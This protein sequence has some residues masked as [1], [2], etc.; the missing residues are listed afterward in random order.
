MKRYDALTRLLTAEQVLE[1]L[2]LC[3]TGILELQKKSTSA[4]PEENLREV[5]DKYL[6]EHYRED[7]SLEQLADFLHFNPSYTSDLFKRIFGKPFVSYLTSMRVETA[8]VLL[9]RGK[10]KTYEIAEHVGYQDEKYFF[11]TFKKVTGFT[12]KEYRKRHLK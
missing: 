11:K 8:K 9:E 6:R 1:Q 5:I 7:I 12:P 4:S 3:G 2:L 10:F